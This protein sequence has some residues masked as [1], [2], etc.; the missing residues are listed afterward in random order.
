ML[1]KD[2]KNALFLQ[3]IK[4]RMKRFL[5][6]LLF[7]LPVACAK[8]V[9]PVG[10]PKDVTP[11]QIVK[12]TPPNQSPYFNSKIIKI[13]FDEFVVLNNPADRVI[14][15]PPISQIPD[16]SLSRKSLI[17]KFSDTLQSNTTY[18]IAFPDCVKDFTEG[19]SIPFF[20]YTFST[21]AYIDS[22]Y[23][24][25]EITETLSL[26]PA[27][28]CFVFLYKKNIDSLPKTVRP[29]YVT[30]TDPQGHFNFTNIAEGIYKIFALKDINQ[31]YI[32][33]LPNE[34]IA[35]QENLVTALPIAWVDSAS[36]DSLSDLFV[37]IESQYV[38]L[39]LFTEK[40]TV[41][42]EP[43]W[44]TPRKGVYEFVFNKPINEYSIN[45]LDTSQ[46]VEWFEKLSSQRDTLTLFLKQPI[47]DSLHIEIWTDG[48][49][50]D[51][52][53]L[54]PFR[55]T[56]QR[57]RESSKKQSDDKLQVTSVNA[58]HLYL[59]MMLNFSGPI[60][61][62]D[63]VPVMLIK[64]KNSGN[65]TLVDYISIPD[66]LVT[67]YPLL[68][69][70]EE[71]VPYTMIFQDSLFWSYQGATHDSLFFNFTIK[72]DKDYG[73]LMMRYQIEEEGIGYII[74]LISSKD[75]IIQTD[76]ILSSR[77][78]YYTHLIPDHYKIKVIEDVNLNGKWD[79]G[80][81][82]KKIQ[83]EKIFYFDK[84]IIIRGYWEVEE[85]FKISKK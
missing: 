39:T 59:P 84:P 58:D 82:E 78:I 12:A 72:S 19:N 7:L 74:S 28:D 53:H 48:L 23:V 33:D 57:G 51:T 80:N 38:H 66:G 17:I 4:M 69:K 37:Q 30:R 60:R 20:Q 21:G 11:P 3:S 29:D 27:S 56:R 5:L 46:K 32:Y 31:N 65:D 50:R 2:M 36:K 63:S 79:T 1:L 25:G 43:K 42:R 67:A 75:K 40:D 6:P 61:P 22:F 77:K 34:S 47:S 54:L 70:K 76:T 45:H 81:Y 49:Y 55:E 83:P 26:Q 24:S 13:T 15:S 10:G 16:F 35:F 64:R 41:H 8:I 44:T 62:V 14:F 85:V 18:N 9:A 68:F 52:C 71:K 73:D